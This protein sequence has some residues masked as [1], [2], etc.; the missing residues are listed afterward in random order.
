LPVD[1]NFAM[2]LTRWYMLALTV[3]IIALQLGIAT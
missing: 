2:A 3:A 1:F